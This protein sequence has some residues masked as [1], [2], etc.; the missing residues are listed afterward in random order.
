MGLRLVWLLAAGAAL[1]AAFG[2]AATT[3]TP[4]PIVVDPATGCSCT[5]HEP[6]VLICF[7][8]LACARF[9]ANVTVPSTRGVAGQD[10]ATMYVRGTRI[11]VLAV[12]DLAGLTHLT[13]MGFDNSKALTLVE[14]RAFQDMRHLVNLS[15]SFNPRLTHLDADALL[16]L[17]AL[18]EL[19][20]VRNGFVTLSADVTPSLRPAVLPQLRVL[21][22]DQN[23]LG[24]VAADAFLP[25]DGAPLQQL[26]LTRCDVATV[27]RGWLAPLRQLAVLRLADNALSLAALADSLD[28]LPRGGQRVALRTLDLGAVGINIGLHGVALPASAFTSTTDLGA[29]S[30]VDHVSEAPTVES[31]AR[32]DAHME[33]LR[34]IARSRVEELVLR[35]NRVERL[36]PS[37]FPRM[38][39]LRRLDLSRVELSEGLPGA[40]DAH[41]LPS[42][43]ALDLSFNRLR[44]LRPGFVS[45]ELLS[46]DLG[47][48][49][50]TYF[51]VGDSSFRG[52]HRLRELR[53]SYSRV[54]RLTNATF[55]GLDSLEVLELR[56]A[57]IFQL[58]D[59]VFATLP[60]LQRLDLHRNEFPKHALLRADMFLGLGRLRVLLLGASGVRSL[61]TDVFR[62]L[63]ALEEL[64]LQDNALTTLDGCA[65]FRPLRALRLLD[66]SHNRFGSWQS[67]RL[68]DRNEALREVR[69]A[70]NTL[71][72]LSE[73]MLRDLGGLRV[74]DLADNTFHCGC[75]LFR[76]ASA[77]L[78]K[79]NGLL[80]YKC[81]SPDRWRGRSLGE[82]VRWAADS[83]DCTLTSAA[84]KAPATLLVVLLPVM[85][86]LLLAL[87]VVATM[88][89]RHRHQ[90]RLH[91]DAARRR[92][93]A[94]GVGNYQ[95]DAFVSY[96][97]EDQ[98]FVHKLVAELEG[99]EPRLRLCVY[100]RDFAVG[101]AITEEVLQAVAQSRRV[102][103]V[104]S[105][106]F[107]RSH[108]CAWETHIAH[109]QRLHCGRED[110]L[111]VVR[112][113]A[114]DEAL[115]TPTLRY[116][117]QTRIYLEWRHGDDR[118]DRTHQAF[119][120][121]LRAALA[122]SPS[123]SAAGAAVT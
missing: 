116:L 99:G 5:L 103:L 62:H 22:L 30:T 18:R 121:K 100:E 63:P 49:L 20:L 11:A 60:R 37:L 70:G 65:A 120:R 53:L 14:P 94:D 119:W 54:V 107:A 95:Y 67:A 123:R 56:N 34:A 39:R 28:L 17:V 16:G 9:P 74:V 115:L 111:L 21:V 114:V 118:D 106:A 104:V 23:V 3:T 112:L 45:D 19:V 80:E 72:Y 98:V 86:V 84:T 36:W 93:A 33:L 29:A 97:S 91:W 71:T 122:P 85:L 92:K 24:E 6:S 1:G 69:A 55:V 40:L 51:D 52:L 13:E 89:Y 43:Q 35:Q 68:F 82:Y 73:A 88:A 46:L 101:A 58:D 105:Q 12:G 110:A 76:P 48:S 41:V 66:V 109:H 79:D 113:G 7:D 42:L 8:M 15:M 102:L 117:L 50:A 90:L 64:E 44:A 78:D 10:T 75:D 25:M 32:P 83:G 81:L 57:T 87:A 96:S 61:G 27:H 38:P 4:A 77:L 108:W 2:A 47:N 31:K 26:S 59:G